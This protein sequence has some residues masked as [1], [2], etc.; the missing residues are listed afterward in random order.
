MSTLAAYDALIARKVRKPLAHG[1]E[2]SMALNAGLFDWQRL[3]VEWA[4]NQG[5]CALFEDCGLGKTLQQL[6]WARHVSAH[7][8]GPVL[9][10]CPLAVAAQ[11]VKEGERF[12]IKAKHV[13]ENS[14][15]DVGISVTN[16][17]RLDKF[18]TSIFSGVV[19]D[20]SS[21]L[22]SFMGKT[23]AA[24]CA[25]FKSTPF[26]LCCT[27]TPAPNDYMEFGQHSDFL[28]V[29]DS[30]EM[31]SRY[32]INDT[33]NFGNYR[34]KGHA[35]N[36]F[37]KW[38]ATWAACV[39][40]PSDIGFNDA[41]FE[42][43]LL[44]IK[45]HVV[46]VDQTNGRGDELFR[47]PTLSATNIHREFRMTC[48]KRADKCAE[49][50]NGS[51]ESWVVWCNTNQ[52]ADALVERIPDAIEVRGSDS[53]ESKETNLE[54]FTNGNARVI[55][56]KPSIAGYGLNWQHCGNHAFVGLSYSFEDFY[57]AMRRGYRFGRKEPFN[58]HIIQADTESSVAGVVKRKM[59][60]HSKMKERMKIAAKEL[61]NAD[62][63]T[64]ALSVD[65]PSK[66]GDSWQ[67]YNGDCVRVAA[68][69]PDNTIHF[70]VYSPPFS[71]LY[72]YSSDVQD[73]GNCSN[74]SEFFEQYRH[75][76]RE[77]LRI[78]RPGCLTAV[79]CKNLVQY[80]G[81][82]GRSG[83]RD[84]RGEIIR[85]HEECGWQYH[86]EVTI[87]KC[88][89]TE[90]TRTKAQG[91]LYKQL[92]TDSRFSRMGMSE[93]VC[94][95]RKWADGMDEGKVHHTKDEFALDDWQKIASPVW[96]D[97]NQTRVLNGEIAREAQDEKHICPLQLDVIERL[98]KLYTNTGDLVFSP[99]A[100][101]GS[102]GYCAVKA[103]RKFCGA[104]L[105]ESY[106]K[107]ACSYIE[108]AESDSLQLFKP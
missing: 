37:W 23:R 92:R 64:L 17:E 51:K 50:V 14:E 93:Y 46:G 3:L 62:D 63:K 7:T 108:R 36:E 24:L 65:I 75:L 72:I 61:R 78:T 10:L 103:S 67:L 104:E 27:A 66:S 43:P 59:E 101:I 32:F 5:R 56:T 85:A 57:Q 102:E 33:M 95:F 39:S 89:V 2:T 35:E 100:G 60:Q 106:F 49:L 68:S 83:M 4:I 1:F 16:Y 88:P 94:I 9:I 13:F 30:N 12:G 84:F 45:S 96:M 58:V 99:F 6:E 29:M 80:K 77:K 19:L 8:G 107:I 81:R 21:I 20:E 34:L 28:G 98:L 38:V 11:T 86:S 26:R 42:L 25:A 97:V 55:I 87:W 105:K 22:K 44:S 79:H 15:I 18:D 47:N 48:D 74:D 70:S 90:M 71:N 54:R 40:K 73:M 53:A 82:D 69:I 41:G 52:E 76:I 31:L 91:L